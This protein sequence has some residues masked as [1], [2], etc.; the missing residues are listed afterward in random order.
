[1]EILNKTNRMKISRR[2]IFAGAMIIFS[3]VT[4]ANDG[5]YQGSGSTLTITKNSH[6]RVREEKLLIAPIIS[7][8]CYSVYANGKIIKNGAIITESARITLGSRTKCHSSFE[9]LYAEWH[10][11]ADYQI[12]VLQ[13]QQNVLIGFPV[14][15]W[16]REYNAAD[17]DLYSV[18]APGVVNF[19]TYINDEE[20]KPL[21]LKKLKSHNVKAGSRDE[22]GYTWLGSFDAGKPYHLRTEYDFGADNS[23]AFYG[24]SE[25]LAGE[26]PWFFEVVDPGQFPANKLKYYLSPI[27]SWASPPPDQ[28][29]IEVQLPLE[30]PVT[31][32]VPLDLKPVCVTNKALH[33]LLKNQFPAHELLLSMPSTGWMKLKKA[34]FKPLHTLTQWNQ[35]QKTLGGETV[36]IGCDVIEDLKKSAAPDLQAHMSAYQC[37]VSCSE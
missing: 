17:G 36:K 10:A 23:N 4:M 31:Y 2:N 34:R 12:D 30:I 7:S 22:L 14:E 18:D 3:N 13:S 37:V 16:D 19:R 29:R 32:F 27:N 15:T 6:L 25:Y 5:F 35:W 1:M 11:K 21:E 8:E 24:G 33:Y 28:I 26:T 20:V 9:Q